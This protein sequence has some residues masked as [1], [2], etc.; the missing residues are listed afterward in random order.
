MELEFQVKHGC[1]LASWGPG[2]G[3]TR[4]FSNQYL[5]LVFLN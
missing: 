5:S 3:G 1:T 4:F 2:D